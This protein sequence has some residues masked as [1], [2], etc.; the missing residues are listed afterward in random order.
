MRRLALL[1]LPLIFVAPLGA[2]APKAK[3]AATSSAAVTSKISA[4]VYN[5]DNNHALIGWTINHFG[6]NDYFG[7]FSQPTGTLNLDPAKPNAATVMIEIPINKVVTGSDKLTGHLQTAD[8]FNAAKFATA[9]FKSTSVKVSG[10]T[11][12]ITGDLTMLGITKPIT[13]NA[14]LSG[15]GTN[16]LSKKETVGFHATGSIKRSDW[17]ITKYL[18]ALGDKVD[19]NITAAFE[20]AG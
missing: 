17:G 20:K 9:T 6:F 10:T 19:L 15:A 16:I 7:M 13:L 11:A 2:A 4:G 5:L 8:F 18:P 14:K 12:V 1:V 3:P